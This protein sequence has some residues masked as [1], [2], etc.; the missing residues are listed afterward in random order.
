MTVYEASAGYSHAYRS[1]RR[2]VPIRVRWAKGTDD[3]LGEVSV[4]GRVGEAVQQA[5][6]STGVYV[7]LWVEHRIHPH[8]ALGTHLVQLGRVEGAFALGMASPWLETGL[9]WLVTRE[10]RELGPDRWGAGPPVAV[11]VEV[12]G[13]AVSL[14]T[15]VQYDA[16]VTDQDNDLVWS[17]QL[18][19]GWVTRTER[20]LTP[21][22]PVLGPI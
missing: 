15:D 4:R 5:G 6:V 8:L 11:L 12:A 22:P 19:L 14:S 18:G 9:S 1:G 21:A 7:P 2:G 16:Y 17:V 3:W 13:W 20:R 10:S